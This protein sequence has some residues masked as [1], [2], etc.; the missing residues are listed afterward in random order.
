MNEREYRLRRLRE[1]LESPGFIALPF[2]FES[3]GTPSRRDLAQQISNLEGTVR[4]L[5]RTL[6]KVSGAALELL[7]M[8]ENVAKDTHLEVG[9]PGPIE[10]ERLA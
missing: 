5:S 9:D 10:T 2:P 6:S 3:T 8:H 4:D 7:R 1:E